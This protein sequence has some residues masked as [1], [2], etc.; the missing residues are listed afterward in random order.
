[1]EHYIPA[2]SVEALRQLFELNLQS[3]KAE[4]TDWLHSEEAE[5]VLTQILVNVPCSMTLH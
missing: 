5:P 3:H 2:A 4:V 1:M